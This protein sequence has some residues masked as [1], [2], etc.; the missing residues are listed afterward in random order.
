MNLSNPSQYTLVTFLC[1]LGAAAGV[2]VCWGIFHQFYRDTEEAPVNNT[3]QALY[4]RQIRLQNLQSIAA[5]LGKK[6]VMYLPD[7]DES[8]D[9][10]KRV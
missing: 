3:D 10:D 4:M 9:G 8:V 1:I 5:V 2:I 6:G 7:V